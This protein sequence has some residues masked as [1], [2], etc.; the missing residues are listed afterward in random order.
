MPYLFLID[1]TYNN[2]SN[3]N[4]ASS[5]IQNVLNTYPEITPYA[6]GPYSPGLTSVGG[7][8]LTLSVVAPDAAAIDAIRD[9]MNAAWSAGTRSTTYASVIRIP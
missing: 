9:A 7:S 2:G 3:R 1:N 5:A 6:N 4:S 8:S